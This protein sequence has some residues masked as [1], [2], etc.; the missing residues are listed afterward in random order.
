MRPV[1]ILFGGF[2]VV[3]KTIAIEGTMSSAGQT[4]PPAR[5]AGRQRGGALSQSRRGKR[6]TAISV[7]AA[8]A[9][10]FITVASP[11]AAHHYDS[12]FPTNNF[13]RDCFDGE[14]GDGTC[15]TDSALLAVWVE[16]PT[17]TNADETQVRATLD[18]SF[19]T[20]DLNV[21]YQ[22]PAVLT[23]SAETDIVYAKGDPP[24]GKGG[25]A[26]CDD[27]VSIIECD[28]H[29]V[30]FKA[31][32]AVSKGLACHETGHAVGLKHGDDSSPA[33]LNNSVSLKC[34]QD[35]I[36]SQL[37]GDHNAN[38]INATY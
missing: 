11:I 5:S 36:G 13:D 14:M 10:L 6:R 26:W 3:R 27:A 7:S 22:D 37:L 38:Q 1:A 28:Q 2:R 19:H 35:P 23:G 9:V 16:S 21:I 32:N 31:A 29:Y 20:T 15:Q 24:A 34:M 17:L 18:G 25:I 30:T 12:M 8:A 4:R 33:V